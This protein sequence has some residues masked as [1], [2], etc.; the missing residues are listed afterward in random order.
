MRELLQALSGLSIG[1]LTGVDE[2]GAPMVRTKLDV[3]APALVAW[4]PAPPRWSECIGQR[5]VLAH[6]DELESPIVVAL[7]DSPEARGSAVLPRA[8][9]LESEQAIT[10]KCGRSS[11][12]LRADGHVSVHGSHIVSRSSGPNKIKGGSVDI[13]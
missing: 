9:K 3:V 6:V 5:V 11:I 8:I 4:M 12:E 1:R 10:L 13:N 2:N 7:L